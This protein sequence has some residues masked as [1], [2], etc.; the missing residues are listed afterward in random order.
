[1]DENDVIRGVPSPSADGQKQSAGARM[2]L[3]DWLQCVVTAVVFGI[4]IFVFIGRT[5]GVDGTS[6]LQTLHHEDRVIMW[7]LFYKPS[8]GDIV[9]IKTSSY[10]DKPLVKR[11]IAMGGDTVDIDFDKG[12]V[13]VNGIVL[14]E[15]Y[16]NEPTKNELNFK[17]P[18]TV[19]EGHIFVLGDNRNKSQDSRSD[20]VGFID[21]RNVLG[22][23]LFVVVPGKNEFG[24]RDWS[25]VG[26]VYGAG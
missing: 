5:I 10:G 23:V 20:S 7:S 17:G 25:R 19:P 6:M 22:K 3:Y 26:S 21:V 12:E 8:R 11:V 1:M 4:L 9:I 13:S 15:D 14:D 18:V 16:I 2:E 24:L